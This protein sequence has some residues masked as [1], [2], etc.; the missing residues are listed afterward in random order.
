MNKEAVTV[1]VGNGGLTIQDERRQE[2]TE[3]GCK[4]HRIERLYGRF[5]RNFTLPD[6]VDA[7]KVRA[8]YADGMLHLHLPKSEKAKVKPKQ[9]EAKIA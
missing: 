1:T 4:H 6:T 7:A 3:S 8:E 5:A 9:I 2:Q